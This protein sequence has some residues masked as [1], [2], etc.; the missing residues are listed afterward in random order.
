M[1]NTFD[2][3]SVPFTR[4]DIGWVILCVGMAIGGAMIF[5][6][7]QVGMTGLWVFLVASAIAYPGV[8]WF[9]DIYLQSLTATESANDYTDIITQYL[10]KNWAMLLSILYFLLM[11]NGIL[12]YSTG[13]VRDSSEHLYNNGITSFSLADDTFWWAP[14]IFIVMVSIAAQGEK[15]LFKVSGPLVIGKLGII[16][17]LGAIMI[18]HWDFTNIKP[19]TPFFPFIRDVFITIP[20]AVFSLVFMPILSP[21]YVG[22]C[23]EASDKKTATYRAFRASRIAFLILIVS[24]LFFAVSFTLALPYEEAVNAYEKNISALALASNV[25]PGTM[26]KVMSTALNIFALVTAF[27]ALYL[28]LHEG[29]QGIIFN[30][31][32]RVVPEEKINK[33]VLHYS[34]ALVIILGLWAYVELNIKVVILL[35]LGAPLF[36]IVACFIPVLLVYMTPALHHLKGFKAFYVVL[37]GIILCISPFLRL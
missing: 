20:F 6:P 13:L 31:L 30:M 34:V 25:L 17:L 35:S 2:S 36:G 11:L 19:L 15:L 8:Y 21:L 7:V 33:K 26:I 3:K 24:V 27:F 22:F 5:M 1:T 23:K 29:L 37:F 9:Q 16:L 12:G 14:I 4:Y 32:S 18:P 28:S 10:G